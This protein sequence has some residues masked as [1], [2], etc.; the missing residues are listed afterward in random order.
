[1]TGT[2]GSLISWSP[3]AGDANSHEVATLEDLR[4]K[5]PQFE[6]GSVEVG[7]SASEVLQSPELKNLAPSRPL[8]VEAPLPADVAKLLGWPARNAY[9]PGAYGR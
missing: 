3:A 9:Q 2:P 6:Q 4:A 1:M 5:L 8:A 7:A